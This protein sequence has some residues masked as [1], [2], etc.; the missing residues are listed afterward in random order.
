MDILQQNRRDSFSIGMLKVNNWVWRYEKGAE[1]FWQF[2]DVLAVIIS[3][4]SKSSQDAKVGKRLYEKIFDGRGLLDTQRAIY[5]SPALFKQDHNVS[6]GYLCIVADDCVQYSSFIRYWSPIL[7]AKVFRHLL[8]RNLRHDIA[9][10]FQ[11]SIN[12]MA[13]V[14][15]GTTRLSTQQSSLRGSRI[16]YEISK[17]IIWNTDSRN[18]TCH[19]QFP[20]SSRRT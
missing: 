5:L 4:N 3:S 6:F 19:P 15:G 2:K 9:D 18:F 10:F 20:P 7:S 8:W 1:Q 17:W 14:R 13:Q 12:K 11:A 16:S